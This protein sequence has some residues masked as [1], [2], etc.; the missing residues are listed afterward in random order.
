[1]RH[2]WGS[3]FPIKMFQPWGEEVTDTL[4]KQN[5]EITPKTNY[6]DIIV[7]KLAIT[8]GLYFHYPIIP[9]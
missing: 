4:W 7:G 5:V 9:E 8:P 3:Q 6:Y 2:L 1:M